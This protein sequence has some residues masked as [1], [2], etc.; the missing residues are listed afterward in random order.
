MKHK[1][2]LVVIVVL[3][4][5][6]I[7]FISNYMTQK[8]IADHYHF[9]TINQATNALHSLPKQFDELSTAILHDT[10][11]EDQFMKIADLSSSLATAENSFSYV[12]I[13]LS[14]SMPRTIGDSM[15]EISTFFRDIHLYVNGQIRRYV[16]GDET[17]SREDIL[18][19]I[20]TFHQA[21]EYLK[22]HLDEDILYEG[23]YDNVKNHWSILTDEITTE[24]TNNDVLT[25]YR[26][27]WID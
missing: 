20:D 3:V 7:Y 4:F 1:I 14:H 13:Y 9:M 5:S 8:W 10:S 26:E 19:H 21:T 24:F 16:T 23:T 18:Y 2:F 27:W 17:I 11:T 15:G 12:N 6:N 22:E 25:R